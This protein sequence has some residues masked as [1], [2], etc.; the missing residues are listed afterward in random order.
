MKARLEKIDKITDGVVSFSFSTSKI[1]QYTAGQFIEM[2]LPDNTPD[3]RG[4]KRWFTLSSSPTED[5]LTITTKFADKNSSDFKHHLHTLAIGDEIEISEAMGDFVL[6]KDATLP[7]IFIAG[8]IGVTPYRSIIKWLND[9][10]ELRD[11][12]VLL[13]ANTEQDIVFADTFAEYGDKPIEIVSSPSPGWNGEVG[14]LTAERIIELV[15]PITNQRIYISGPEQM[16]EA[17]QKGLLEHGLHES[18]LVGDFFPGYP[19]DLT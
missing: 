16:V 17:L 4:P 10:K 11:I 12:K 2:Y 13:A 14:R 18:Q 19:A 6:P 15:G 5:L 7:L 3:S 8:G 1:L 9:T